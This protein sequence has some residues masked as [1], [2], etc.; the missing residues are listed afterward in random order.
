MN[1]TL[2]EPNHF[3][4]Q[5]ELLKMQYTKYLIF[6]LFSKVSNL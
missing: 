4:N 5:A 6:D 3:P 2:R 1:K